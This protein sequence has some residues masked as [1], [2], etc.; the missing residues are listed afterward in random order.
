MS[1][2]PACAV[3]RCLLPGRPPRLPKTGCRELSAL[4]SCPP[5]HLGVGGNL[6][7]QLQVRAAG[8]HI[9]W[10]GRLWRLSKAGSNAGGRKSGAAHPS[11]THLLGK[12][13]RVAVEQADPAQALQ[14]AQLLQHLRQALAV[15][16]VHAVLVG[17]LWA[18]SM[19]VSADTEND[20]HTSHRQELREAHTSAIRLSSTTPLSTRWRASSNTAC[21]GLD[22][23]LPLREG[24]E[25]QRR[26]I[27]A[28]NGTVTWSQQQGTGEGAAATARGRTP[29][30]RAGRRLKSKAAGQGNGT[31][32][33]LLAI[34]STITLPDHCSQQHLS[35]FVFSCGGQSRRACG[36]T[37]ISRQC[38]P[39][40]QGRAGPARRRPH[41]KASR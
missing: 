2:C 32:H 22:R 14:L 13:A 25:V 1:A 8:Q 17:I 16:P 23:N 15:P 40:S 3:R 27:S 41:P 18:R 26:L 12:V 19:Q 5:S 4:K 39:G 37:G 6:I 20:A 34:G 38:G 10:S 21:Q 31:L 30:W 7:N 11:T 28:Q 35:L 9:G 33:R 36:S 29:R 24:K